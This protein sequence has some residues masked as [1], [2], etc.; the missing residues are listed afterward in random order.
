MIL[1]SHTFSSLHLFFQFA[2][3]PSALKKNLL[4]KHFQ[5]SPK[6]SPFF[7][8]SRVA[9]GIKKKYFSVT[10]SVPSSLFPPSHFPFLPLFSSVPGLPAAFKKF[11]FQTLTSFLFSSPS[12]LPFFEH[13]FA[14]FQLH[15]FPAPFQHIFTCLLF[16]SYTFTFFSTPPVPCSF[17][18]THFQLSPTLIFF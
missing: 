7:F 18:L 14:F 3:W 10:L 8:S 15:G 9:F 13:T 5:L 6:H 17:F 4:K 16:F 2:G 1:F 12:C 11:T